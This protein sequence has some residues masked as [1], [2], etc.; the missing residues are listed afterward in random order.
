MTPIFDGTIQDGKL[1]LDKGEKF[2][3]YLQGLNGKRVQVAVEKLKHS[4]TIQQNRYYWG[5][6]VRLIAQHTGHDPEQIHELLKQ[7]FSPKWYFVIGEVDRGAVPTS[8]T[9]MDTIQFVDYRVWATEFLG[10]DIPLPGEV[11]ERTD[12]RLTARPIW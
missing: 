4:R 2:R 6:V 10:L 3:Q 1:L 11:A 12:T 7:R 9:R 5:V 8:T